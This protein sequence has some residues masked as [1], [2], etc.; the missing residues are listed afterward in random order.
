MPHGTRRSKSVGER[1]EVAGIIGD[2]MKIYVRDCM[3]VMHQCIC[4]HWRSCKLQT[5]CCQL[6]VFMDSRVNLAV[7]TNGHSHPPLICFSS[8]CSSLEDLSARV[9]KFGTIITIKDN[10]HKHEQ[11]P[12]YETSRDSGKLSA[13]LLEVMTITL[14]LTLTIT[15]TLTLTHGGHA[16]K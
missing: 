7:D 4:V 5:V 13:D 14:T 15:L 6:Q 3:Q 12:R 1:D 10:P 8:H 9:A 11:D 2:T 16:A